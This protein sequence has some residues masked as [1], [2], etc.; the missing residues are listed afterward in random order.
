MPSAECARGTAT[1]RGRPVGAQR[2]SPVAE[3]RLVVEAQQHPERRE[4]LV[5]AYEPSIARIA[6]MYCRSAPAVSRAELMQEGVVGLLRALNRYD[7]KFGVPFW[8]YA[9]WWVRQAMQQLVAELSGPVVLSDRALRQLARIKQA[10]RDCGQRSGHEPESS[11]LALET[12]LPSAQIERLRTAERAAI[13]VDE[14]VGHDGGGTLAELLADPSTDDPCDVATATL[15]AEQV[16][17]LLETL[18]ERECVVV[19]ERFGF[20][21]PERTLAVIGARLGVSAE[22]VR[23]VECTALEKLRE[24]FGEPWHRALPG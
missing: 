9:S 1:R 20:D 2:L 5:E 22:R 6:R 8:V 21:G 13:G 18:T 12:G 24:R 11:M 7:L 16:P 15:L 19:R 14:P 10:E 23:Q 3:R 4:R 17:W